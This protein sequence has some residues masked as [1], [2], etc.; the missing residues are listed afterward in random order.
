MNPLKRSSFALALAALVAAPAVAQPQGGRG[1]GMMFSRSAAYRLVAAPAAHAELGLSEDQAQKLAAIPEAIAGSYREKFQPLRELPQE[2]RQ[3]KTA[4]LMAEVEQ[5]ICGRVKEVLEPEQL[6]RFEQIRI[7]AMGLQAFSDPTVVEKLEI[8]DAQKGKVDSLVEEL[9][10]NT[11]E[12]FQD[13][14]GDFRAAGEKIASLRK[15]A[16]ERAVKELTED[17]KKAWGELT[18]EPFELPPMGPP[19]GGRPPGGTPNR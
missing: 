19:G 12:A 15:E 5:D 2:E 1:M 14:Q 9:D 10:A 7:Q 8:T 13:A 3:E 4:A 17:Q 16:F 18:G 11:R 6:E